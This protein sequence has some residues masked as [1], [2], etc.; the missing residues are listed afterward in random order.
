M[1]KM[2]KNKN[3]RENLTLNHRAKLEMLRNPK[4]IKTFSPF[5]LFCRDAFKCARMINVKVRK[6]LKKP[7]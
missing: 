7:G 3:K 1:E 6:K 5:F 4:E 2:K